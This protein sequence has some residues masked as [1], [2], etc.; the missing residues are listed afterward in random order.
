MNQVHSADVLVLDEQP[1]ELPAVDALVTRVPN[2]NLTVKTAD[3]APILLADPTS[4]MIAAV[5]AGWRGALQG[6]IEA[7]V[8]TMLRQGAC[9]DTIR[10]GIGPHIQV[11]SF[12]IGP[13]IKA[14]FPVTEHHF[15]TE[16][17]GRI[18]FDFDAYVVHRLK[19]TGV[20]SIVSTGDDTYSDRRYNSFRRDQTPNRQFSSILIREGK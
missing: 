5:H 1:T 4:R 2:L 15:F 13:E 16:D 20:Q 9:I 14:L 12:E 8:L 3:C 11:Q 18:L 7:T 6:I 17:G 10:A 19:R